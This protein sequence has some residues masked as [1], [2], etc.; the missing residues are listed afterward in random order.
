MRMTRDVPIPV[1]GV[2]V[3]IAVLLAMTLWRLGYDSV[4]GTRF[5]R[6]VPNDIAC[7]GPPGG[8]RFDQPAAALPDNA[9]EKAAGIEYDDRYSIRAG[10]PNSLQRLRNEALAAQEDC[11]PGQCAAEAS[12][13]YRIAV[14][15]YLMRRLGRTSMMERDHGEPGVEVAKRV[16]TT[17]DDRDIEK[18]IVERA[19]TG[20]YNPRELTQRQVIAI[21]RNPSRGR[22]YLSPCPTRR[23]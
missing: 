23:L 15:Q 7:Y 1:N 11:Q 8:N 13:R 6:Q 14:E 19:R 18:G 21:L 20:L 16:Y 22:E 5:E 12:K 17:F 9:E 10:N 3:F 4:F 2:T